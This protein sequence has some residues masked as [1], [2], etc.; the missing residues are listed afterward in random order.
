MPFTRLAPLNNKNEK[1]K[2]EIY[3]NNLKLF[4]TLA[5]ILFM[6]DK[7]THTQNAVVSKQ[8]KQ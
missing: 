8:H 7:H 6:P 4:E 3:S 2:K 5:F 1:K